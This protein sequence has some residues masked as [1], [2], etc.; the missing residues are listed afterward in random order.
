M[1]SANNMESLACG[2]AENTPVCDGVFSLE[3]AW[4]GPAPKAGQFFMVKPL[5]CS[6]FLA[7]PLSVMEWKGASRTVKF[8]IALRGKGTEELSLMRAGEEAQLT[9][10]LGNAWADFLPVEG[11]TALIGGGVGIAPLAALVA[12]KP[13]Y[14]FHFYA[15]F[16]RG[17]CDK[18]ERAA[19]LGAALNVEK[20]IIAAE[21]GK[22]APQGLIVDFV[23]WDAEYS[24]LFACGPEPMLQAVKVRSDEAGIPCFLSLENRFA[25][26]L[27]ACLG[28]TVHTVNGNR[29]CCADG[30][31]FAARELVFDE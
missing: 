26:G 27:G 10:P 12:E 30:P 6:F 14:G 8:L 3:F 2:L 28:C 16:K 9:G 5:R 19:M 25:C 13:D 31:V 7:R 20:L 18:R 24:S 1:R 15:G 21:D 4:N 11:K 22:N 17:F 23:D 29:R